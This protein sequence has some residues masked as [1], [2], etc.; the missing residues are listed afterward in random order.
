MPICINFS[1]KVL[2][3]GITEADSDLGESLELEESLKLRE[4][5]GTREGSRT[6]RLVRGLP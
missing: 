2:V 5:S 1:K 4:N 3:G 6:G